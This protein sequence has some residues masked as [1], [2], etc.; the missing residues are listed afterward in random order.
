MTLK[1][2]L[3]SIRNQIPGWPC[4]WMY[5]GDDCLQEHHLVRA[6]PPMTFCRDHLRSFDFSVFFCFTH[7]SISR[8]LVFFLL[9]QFTWNFALFFLC[10]YPSHVC[11]HWWWWYAIRLRL[12]LNDGTVEVRLRVLAHPMV[13]ELRSSLTTRNWSSHGWIQPMRKPLQYSVGVSPG[14][15]FCANWFKSCN[16]IFS[17]PL[18]PERKAKF[19]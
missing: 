9:W 1:S 15:I 8:I 12:C 3:F 4:Q 14:M 19:R 18:L 17:L 2:F 7:F 13:T 16:W 10:W 5:A 11:H 6:G